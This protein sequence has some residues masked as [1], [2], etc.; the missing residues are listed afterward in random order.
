MGGSLSHEYHYPSLSGEDTVVSCTNCDY[1]TNEEAAQTSLPQPA[2]NFALPDITVFHGIT[3]DRKT[4]LNVYYPRHTPPT[5]DGMTV[6]NEA[7]AG[8]IRAVVQDFDSSV[9]NALNL[10]F[11]N[12]TEYKDG[13][14]AGSYSQIIHLFDI[15]VPFSMTEMTFSNHSDQPLDREFMTDKR[16]P[17]TSIVFD[18]KTGARINFLKIRT[19]DGCPRCKEGKLKICSAI[20]LGHTFHL[21]TRYSVPLRADV[22][23]EDGEWRPMEMGCHGI[24]VSRMIPAIAEG[25]RDEKGLCWPKIVAPFEV[26][27]VYGLPKRNSTVPPKED[28]EGVYDV[29][30]SRGPEGGSE[31]DVILD[32]RNK[33]LMWKMKD[34]ILVGYPIMCVM[35]RAWTN[36]RKVEI[37]VRRTSSKL[38]VELHELKGVVESLLKEL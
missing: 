27:V 6:L 20:E 34:A 13:S 29:L 5:E 2:S 36:A 30:A 31:I 14:K 15:R 10:F 35:G 9:G 24:G 28:I 3:K 26:V 17:T 32:D 8:K 16:I 23:H 4:L 22:L 12:F 18:P 7:H 19:G 25:Y 1:C 21:G 33:D 11:D 37:E 38:E